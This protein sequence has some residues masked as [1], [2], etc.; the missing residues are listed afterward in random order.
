MKRT[1]LSRHAALILALLLLL[2]PLGGATVAAAAEPLEDSPSAAV[3]A[4]VASDEAALPLSAA[5]ADFLG[6]NAATLLSGATFALTMLMTLVFRK[7][8]I[9]GIL[10]A[11]GSLLGKSREAIAT[12]EEGQSAER[13]EISRLL[14]SCEEVLTSAKAAAA[15]AETLADELKTRGSTDAELRL[16]LGE[17]TSLLYELLMSA[18]LPQYQKERIGAAHA[19]ITAVLRE[20]GEGHE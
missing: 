1:K 18:N 2:A 12:M 3:T 13:T 9:P 17:Q 10:E 5:F 16:V 6:E 7:K 20:A 19:A 11:L 4:A 14:S 15:R 8:I